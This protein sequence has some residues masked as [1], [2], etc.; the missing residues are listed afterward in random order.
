M[1]STGRRRHGERGRPLDDP[2]RLLASSWATKSPHSGTESH[3][4]RRRIRPP[5]PNFRAGRSGCSRARWPP[6]RRHRPGGGG[7]RGEARNLPP[8]GIP[9]TKEV[10]ESP[11]LR[12]RAAAL[13]CAN[14][15]RDTRARLTPRPASRPTPKQTLAWRRAPLIRQ[16]SST[17]RPGSSGKL[18]LVCLGR[19]PDGRDS[20]SCGRR[21]RDYVEGES[22]SISVIL[23]MRA[24]GSCRILA[25]TLADIEARR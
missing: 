18:P 7:R 20:G 13:T 2:A 17:F 14:G 16:D 19:S 25:V 23:L 9:P 4:A 10:G 22:V 6:I 8:L 11:A 15:G 24:T 3:S 12:A 5:P 21:C 1:G